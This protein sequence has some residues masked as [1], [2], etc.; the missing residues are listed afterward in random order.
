[1][2][3]RV[4]EH[5]VP[6]V[7]PH[8]LWLNRLMHCESM[9]ELRDYFNSDRVAGTPV[10]G[11]FHAIAV[12]FRSLTSMV[13]LY[14]TNDCK[15]VVMIH[16]GNGY[17]IP[18]GEWSLLKEFRA[19]GTFSRALMRCLW[20][21]EELLNRR[22]TGTVC[23]RFVYQRGKTKPGLSPQ[24]RDALQSTHELMFGKILLRME[25][26]GIDVV[27]LKREVC[28]LNTSA[29]H[30]NALVEELCSRNTTS[31]DENKQLRYQNQSL[32]RRVEELEQ[33]SRLSNVE[34]K[35]VF[36]S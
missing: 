13:T 9:Y 36:C 1:M 11:C 18:A 12:L 24:K 3:K 19:D 8:S 22:V 33:Y 35:G 15:R 14:K 28:S 17:F 27:E 25:E 7:S 5:E 20:K 34:I 29:E 31:T 16:I 2:C 6:K 4:R 32:T 26:S 21:R 30:L 23:P 10:P